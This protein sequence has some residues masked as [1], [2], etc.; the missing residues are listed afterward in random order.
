MQNPKRTA[1]S[2]SLPSQAGR[3][4]EFYWKMIPGQ[5]WQKS[6]I[7][8]DECNGVGV[9]TTGKC[10]P[11]VVVVQVRTRSGRGVHSVARQLSDSVAASASLYSS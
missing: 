8:W 3:L 4:A 7:R 6:A 9:S 10:H 2:P 11:Q 5:Q 1:G